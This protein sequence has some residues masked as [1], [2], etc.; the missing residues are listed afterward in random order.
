MARFDGEVAIVTGAARGIGAAY[1]RAFAAEGARVVVTDI[2]DPASV[3]DDIRRGDGAALGIVAYALFVV[4]LAWEIVRNDRRSLTFRYPVA[5]STAFG[6]LHGFGFAAVLRD[7]GL[8]QTALSTA[9]LFFNIG[10]EIGQIAFVIALLAG[11]ALL[12][13]PMQPRSILPSGRR[14]DPTMLATPT[15]YVIGGIASYWL[16]DRIAGFWV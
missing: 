12:S 16:I 11:F 15:A 3:V 5:V 2:L 14:L 7:I 8:P 6:L 10:V 9:L 4:F 1:A 13:R